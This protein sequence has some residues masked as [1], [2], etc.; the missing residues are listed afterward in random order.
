MRIFITADIHHAIKKRLLPLTERLARQC[1]ER[2]RSGDVLLLAGDNACGDLKGLA[3]LLERFASFPGPRALVPG[4]HDLWSHPEHGMGSDVLYEQAIPELCEKHGFRV[5]DRAPLRVDGP[6]G[7]LGIAGCYGGFDFT[8]GDLDSLEPDDRARVKEGWR[9]GLLEPL[10]WNDYHFTWSA[11]GSG[12]DHASFSG[13]N[14]DRLARHLGEL[15]RDSAVS[16]VI[17]ITHT[18]ACLEEITGHPAGKKRPASERTWFRGI[19]GSARLGEVIRGHSKVRLHVCGHTHHP[20]ETTD[21]GG[22]HWVNVGC[23]YPRK[24]WLV[25]EP[26]RGHEFTEWVEA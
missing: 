15:E 9:T 19:T 1:L 25:V 13:E 20:T 4:N 23:D 21:S 26:G 10:F 2:A 7:Q 22:R 14:S 24:R 6:D 5:L 18:G 11:S 16:E 3:D 12:W 8:L 17:C